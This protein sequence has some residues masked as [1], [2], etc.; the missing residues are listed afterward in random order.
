MAAAETIPA[1]AASVK[2]C[3]DIRPVGGWF[4]GVVVRPAKSSGG[5][6]SRCIS[7]DK[8]GSNAAGGVMLSIAAAGHG[9]GSHEINGQGLS[10][11]NRHPGY[12][13]TGP[14]RLPVR[15]PVVRS[16]PRAPAS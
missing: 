3:A 9:K 2:C 12:L 15:P 7:L 11:L 1:A 5:S 16:E 4:S 10:L 6:A 8:A 14:G 13:L